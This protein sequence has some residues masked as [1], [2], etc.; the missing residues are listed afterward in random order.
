MGALT[1]LVGA[2]VATATVA[3]SELVAGTCA[4]LQPT[5][6]AVAKADANAC[7]A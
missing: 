3:L 7:Q 2:G 1:E 6:A 5:S 4:A